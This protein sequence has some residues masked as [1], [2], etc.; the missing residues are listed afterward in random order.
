MQ[1]IERS[2]G[3]VE[4]AALRGAVTG[5]IIGTVVMTVGVTVAMLNAGA[6]L[7]PAVGVGLFAAFWGGPGFGGMMGAILA[8]VRAEATLAAADASTGMPDRP[9]AIAP[10]N[11]GD[12]HEAAA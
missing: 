8:A 5:T 3:P 6:Q 11:S 9:D 7:V 4:R 1:N 2:E 12:A 10:V